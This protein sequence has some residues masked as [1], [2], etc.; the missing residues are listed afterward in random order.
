M[1]QE[2]DLTAKKQVASFKPQLDPT[3]LYSL[4]K[5]ILETLRAWRF[6][7]TTDVVYDSD[8]DDIAVDGK[9]RA[10]NG[11]GVRAV[12]H[13]AFVV[14]LMRHCLSKDTPHTGF[15]VIDSPSDPISEA[16]TA[17]TLKETRSLQAD[18][19][20]ATVRSLATTEGLGQTIVLE[21][22]RPPG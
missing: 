12:M 21:N 4:Q 8:S 22:I 5:W 7:V 15:V 19:H 11:K 2:A 10:A 14:G 16:P 6:P 1:R 13:A 3:S 20:A 17:T 9:P 18:V